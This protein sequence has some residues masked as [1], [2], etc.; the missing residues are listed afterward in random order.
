M[1][2]PLFPIA[3]RI[4]R[5]LAILGSLLALG[6]QPLGAQTERPGGRPVPG[7]GNLTFT[8]AFAANPTVTAGGSRDFPFDLSCP[9]GAST[10]ELTVSVNPAGPLVSV[11]PT[12]LALPGSATVN[13]ATNLAT[14][15]NS[16]L[17]TLT[18]RVVAGRCLT[19]S[20]SFVVEVVRPIRLEVEPPLVR[21]APGGRA[22]YAVRVRR[23]GI[24][25]PIE[26]RTSGLPTGFDPVFTPNPVVTNDAMLTVAVPNPT[27]EC[28][29]PQGC[30]F[31]IR[32]QAPGGVQVD[33]VE[34]RLV[35]ERSVSFRAEPANSEASPGAT[36]RVQ[37][38][39]DRL[40]YDDVVGLILVGDPRVQVAIAPAGGTVGNLFWLDITLPANISGMRYSFT[41]TPELPAGT[42]GVATASVDF[43]ILVPFDFSVEIRATPLAQAVLPSQPAF[44]DLEILKKNVGPVWYLGVNG[45]PSGARAE[46]N[47]QVDPTRVT[48]FTSPLT[49]PG[50]YL[51]SVQGQYL[52]PNGLQP[53]VFSNPVALTVLG[54]GSTPRVRLTADPASLVLTSGQAGT[55]TIT[56]QRDNCNGT[57]TLTRP[58][59]LPSEIAE[60]TFTPAGTDRF[61][62]RVVAGTVTTPRTVWLPIGAQVSGC[63]GVEVQGTML[64]VTVQPVAGGTVSLALQPALVSIPAG[65]SGSTTIQ[66]TR[67]GNVGAVGLAVVGLPPGVSAA[68]SPSPV[69]GTTATLTLTVGANVP[70]GTTPFQ[71]SGSAP[72]AVVNPAGGNLSVV[73]APAQAPRITSFSPTSGVAGTNVILTGVNL[74]GTFDV[75]F[76]TPSFGFDSIGFTP[77]SDTRVDVLIPAGK[78]S[79]FFRLSTPVD[80]TTS[81]MAFQVTTPNLPEIGGFDPLSGPAET[82]VEIVG[83]NLGSATQVT[84]NGT[85]AMFEP[86]Q[87]N[88]I[89][90]RVP[91]GATTGQIRVTTPAGTAVSFT[92]FAVTSGGPVITG[93]QPLSGR[94]GDS[95]TLAGV[96]LT[97]AFAVTFNGTPGDVG[98][99]TA[100]FVQV[101]VPTGATTGRIVL[102]TPAGPATSPTDFTVLP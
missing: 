60:V 47:R 22:T 20:T 32:G 64:A 12:R 24:A 90:A 37:I 85:P 71:V 91:A 41:A 51:L 43:E 5:A 27:N 17:V 18:A 78:P 99:V 65:G 8:A 7:D 46:A 11:K 14:P 86:P 9:D 42:V 61:T 3:R 98:I 58:A 80:T 26:L 13:F 62:A 87:A 45:L 76:G 56:A 77:M 39:I 49:P 34:A 29:A 31:Q 52:D 28:P 92:P 59:S 69:T 21:A 10:V 93:F 4:A 57:I 33:A 94:P 81:T 83:S 19:R 54:G 75:S 55:S 40:G 53:L 23:G 50:T 97:G 88:R 66:V 35:V 44:V 38:P 70:V 15:S 96:N 72:G 16:Y 6:A 25:G 36:V 67:T 102:T 73:A 84:F 68:I 2:M 74:T 82:R 48:I 89:F 100:N 63:S 79:G 95:I 1:S 30:R 101:F